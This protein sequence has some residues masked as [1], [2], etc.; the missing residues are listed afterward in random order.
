MQ[1]AASNKQAYK[2]N[3]DREAGQK[4]EDI[5]IASPEATVSLTKDVDIVSLI[6]KDHKPLKKLIKIMKDVDENLSKRKEA[7]AEFAPL[8]VAHAKSEEKILYVFMKKEAELRRDG[9]EGD[10]EHGLADQLVEEAK[11]TDDEDWWSARV[12]VLAELVEHHIEEEEDTILP[13]FKKKCKISERKELGGYYLN[14][15]AKIES[16]GS[17]DAPPERRLRDNMA[18]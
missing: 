12:K 13:D 9:L 14:V 3:L 8:L 10:V 16:R 2:K 1:K 7:F 18:H 5:L 11:R 6:L 15:K 4:S 17:D